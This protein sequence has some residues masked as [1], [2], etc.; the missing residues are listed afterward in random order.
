MIFLPLPACGERGGVRGVSTGTLAVGLAES[1]PHPE[2]ARSARIP[3]SPRKRGEAK[4]G[5]HE[6]PAMIARQSPRHRGI[7]TS[8]SWHPRFP[9]P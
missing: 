9:N 1:P 5:H 3:A 4:S 2:S 8:R 6:R 7:R